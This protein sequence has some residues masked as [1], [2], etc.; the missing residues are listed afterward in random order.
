[1]VELMPKVIKPLTELQVRNLKPR[2][3]PDGTLKMNKVLVGNCPNLYT[4]VK[5]SGTK[6]WVL[7]PKLFDTRPEMVLG[8]YAT[9]AVK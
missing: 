4:Y 2:V 5:P 9:N 1:M 6:S 7:R 3:M 8:S